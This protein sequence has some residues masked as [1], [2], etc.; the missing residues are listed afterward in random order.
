MPVLIL[1]YKRGSASA[2]ALSQRL[3]ARQMKVEGS[4]LRNSNKNTIINWGNSTA[5]LSALDKVR[6]INPQVPVAKASNKLKFFEAVSSSE[7]PISIPLWTTDKEV[8]HGWLSD[9]TDVVVRH[10]LQGHSGDGIQMVLHDDLGAEFPDAPLYVAYVKKRDEYRVHVVGGTVTDVQR[11]A[12]RSSTPLDAVNWQIRN[13]SNG[14]VFVRERVDPPQVILDDA[15]KAVKILGLDFGAVDIIWNQNLGKSY[16]IEVNTACGLEGTTLDRYT[17]ALHALLSGVQPPQW[18]VGG[19]PEEGEDEGLTLLNTSLGITP[20]VNRPPSALEPLE[21]ELIEHRRLM[22]ALR[23]LGVADS[24]GSSISSATSASNADTAELSATPPTATGSQVDAAR[25]RYIERNMGLLAQNIPAY[26]PSMVQSRPMIPMDT[27][28][29]PHG[30]IDE[31]PNDG[32]TI[33]HYDNTP[34]SIPDE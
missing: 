25:Q 29:S 18:Q 16:V 26:L 10:K 15:V 30:W 34:E 31:P 8:A 32:P 23:T 5:D 28:L 24:V 20:R 6:V 33:G 2:S 14:F 21:S 13:H 19:V 17:A 22:Q 12:R 27:G 3:G 11:K 7:E 1:P 9:G 4:T